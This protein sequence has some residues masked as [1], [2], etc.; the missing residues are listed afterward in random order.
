MPVSE[1]QKQS[2]YK[3]KAKNIKRIPLDMQKMDYENLVFISAKS[4]KSVN[5]Y[6]KEAIAEKLEREGSK[7]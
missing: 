6:I 3:Y 1:K 4:G 5:G 7:A 2:T